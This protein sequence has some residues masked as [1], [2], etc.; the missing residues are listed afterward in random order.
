MLTLGAYAGIIYS[1][2][3]DSGDL[4]DGGVKLKISGGNNGDLYAYLSECGVR[5][6]VWNRIA[7]SSGSLLGS[8][9]AGLDSVALSDRGSVNT[10]AAGKGVWSGAYKPEGQSTRAR[11][12]AALFNGSDDSVLLV[13]PWLGCGGLVSNRTTPLRAD[14]FSMTVTGCPMARRS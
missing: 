10:D 6:P 2:F 13:D 12:S 7:V 8:S 9:G 14:G 5:V 1:P 3:A 11:R 4:P